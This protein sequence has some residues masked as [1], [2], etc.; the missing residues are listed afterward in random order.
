M[1]KRDYYE[2]LEVSKSASKEEIKK[3]Y[4]KK[5]IQFHPDKNPGDNAAEEKFKEAAEAYEVLSDD[6]KKSRYDQ[7]GHAGVNGGAGFGGGG[8]S[9]D[10]IFSH[11]GDIFGD[12]GGFGF[13]GFG[14]SRQSQR[15]SKGSNLRVKVRMNLQEVAEGVEKKLKLKKYVACTSCDGTGAEGHSGLSTCTACNGTGQVTRITNTILGRMQTSSVCNSCGGSGKII[16]KKCTSC[17]GEGIVQGEEVV[18]VKIP[19]GVAEGMQ[20]NVS[21]KGNAARRGGIN[22]D[23]IVAIEEEPHQELVR[24]GNDLIYPLFVSIPDAITGTTVEIPT[25]NGKAKIKVDPGTQPGKILR[26]RGK[27][28]PDV[29]G[30]GKGDL[31]VTVNVW[32]PKDTSK[33]ERSILEKLNQSKNFQPHPDNEDKSFFKKMRNLFE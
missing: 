4:R 30:Y 27:G 16:T 15:V 5:A 33:E 23:L 24:D 28:I 29:N 21:G 31:L 9:M 22:G 6:N 26:L 11:F 25:V 14:G 7:F 10:D 18:T 1:T 17:Y 2:V 13:G 32:I 3:A 12:I 20:L 19:A 8:M